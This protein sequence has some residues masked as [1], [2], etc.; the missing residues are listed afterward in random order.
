ML[1]FD[2]IWCAAALWDP[3]GG[4]MIETGTGSKNQ[5]SAA[6]ILNFAFWEY[7]GGGSKYLHH[8]R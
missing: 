6:A 3:G 1:D 8:I 7:L 4:L 5:P 2:E